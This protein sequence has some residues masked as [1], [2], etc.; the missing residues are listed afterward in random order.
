MKL[1]LV[2]GCVLAV[3]LAANEAAAVDLFTDGFESGDFATGGWTTQNGD[4]SVS[5]GAAYTGVYGA[6][7]KKATW[8]EKAVSTVGYDTI[9]V[10][11]RRQTNG[12][13]AGENLVVEWYNGSGWNNLETVQNADYSDGL[14]DK[15]CGAGADENADFKIRFLTNT[16]KN[17]E[18]AY[19]DDVVV[20]GTSGVPD[21]DPP[22]PDPATF[23]SAPAAIS[24][25]A[26]TMTATTGSDASPPVEYYF[27]ETSGNPGGSDSGWVTDPEYTDTGL[28]PNT[29]Y[30][31]TVQM[32]DSL[33]NTGAASTPQSATTP[34]SGGT[35]QDTAN[36]D[37]IV[38]GTVTGSYTDT[39]SSDDGYESIEEIESGGKPSKRHSFLEHK[40]SVNVTGGDTVTFYVEAYQTASSD[41][42]NFVFAYSTSQDGTYTD[43]VTVTK[44]VD[45]QWCGIY[46]RQ[47]YGPNPRQQDAGYRLH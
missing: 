41:G 10:K 30:T 33:S 40:W 15:T 2:L 25:S 27:D 8:I 35:V 36:S 20:S 26:I 29:Q 4:A 11:Y 17:N 38:A 12:F 16:D 21:T 37:I 44:T 5:E 34:P 6:K 3:C 22:T 1:T 32:R 47:G 14:Q 42:D 13:D 18:S 7:L 31:Y 46:P 9:H 24:S 39:Q 43:M 45:D 28:D 23:A 19:I